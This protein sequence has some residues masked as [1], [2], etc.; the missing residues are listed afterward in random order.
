M[1]A[2]KA[3]QLVR[4]KPLPP[5]GGWDRSQL[6]DGGCISRNVP[7]PKD[8]ETPSEE[9]LAV[10]PSVPVPTETQRWVRIAGSRARTLQAKVRLVPGTFPQKKE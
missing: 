3:L 4:R 2:G 6:H 9:E 1:P 8:A 7:L 5:A 10:L